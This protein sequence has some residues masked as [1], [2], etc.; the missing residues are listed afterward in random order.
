MVSH[1]DRVIEFIY[2]GI[3]NLVIWLHKLCIYP[4]FSESVTFLHI[5]L[6]I[7]LAV[8]IGYILLLSQ[9]IKLML[10]LFE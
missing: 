6:V 10:I 5:V 8:Y 7:L 4:G 1:G 3:W 2:T 9:W